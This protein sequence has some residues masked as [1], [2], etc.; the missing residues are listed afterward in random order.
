MDV[1]TIISEEVQNYLNDNFKRWFG[2]S[3]VV[4]TDGSPLKLYHGTRENFSE[5]KGELMYFSTTPEYASE[6]STAPDLVKDGGSPAVLPVYLKITNPLDLRELETESYSD[7]E[8][9]SSLFDKEVDVGEDDIRF[10]TGRFLPAW[11]WLIENYQTLV[12]AIKGSGYDG[13]IMYES[14]NARGKNLSDLVYVV[15]QPNQIK[16]AMGN[17]G[18]FSTAPDITKES[19][20]AVINEEIKKLFTQSFYDEQELY[21]V[22]DSSAGAYEY[23]QTQDQPR[24]LT[25]QFRTEDNDYYN[26]YIYTDDRR[27]FQGMDIWQIEFA[28]TGGHKAIINKGRMYKVMASITTIIREFIQKY[29]PNIVYAHPSKNRGSDDQRRMKLYTAFTRKALE[30]VQGYKLFE[31]REF[32]VLIKNDY[33]NDDRDR[34]YFQ[35]LNDR[36]G[37]WE[38]DVIYLINQALNPE[39]LDEDVDK[40]NNNLLYHVTS[41][42]NLED[43]KNYGLLPQFGETVKQA[44]ADYYKID[45]REDSE[46]DEYPR[47]ELEFDGLLFFSEEPNLQYAHQGLGQYDL[48]WN[49]VLLCAVEKNDSIYHKVS[50]YP[51]FEDYQG[52]EVDS[53]EYMSVYDLPIMIETNDWFSF[54]E[55]QPVDLIYGQRLQQFIGQNFEKQAEK[56]I[57]EEIQKLFEVGEAMN[58]NEAMGIN[59]M[60]QEELQQLDEQQVYTIPE[61]AGLMGSRMKHPQESIPIYQKMLFDAYN[62]GGDDAVVNIYTKMAGVEIEAV[63]RGRYM[64]ANLTGGGEPMLEIQDNANHCP[65]EMPS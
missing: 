62:E 57:G 26:V 60:I 54:E 12:P 41:I 25:W 36:G 64:F 9:L 46:D 8:F 39:Q 5:F 40:H 63:T 47:Q 38:T 21:E 42:N 29:Q 23:V 30:V 19:L 24:D 35:D 3:V 51:K 7:E 4:D 32:M 55:Q 33:F 16:S 10:E 45:D 52:Q 20:N 58:E 37:Y 48:K 44:Y 18:E 56:M 27:E 13:I 6:F 31:N 2:N 22:G 34:K 43:V 11:S 50:D 65:D 59:A 1:L 15:F 53:I 61:L 17:N 28:T 49:E 14:N